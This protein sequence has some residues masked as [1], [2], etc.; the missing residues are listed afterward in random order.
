MGLGRWFNVICRPLQPNEVPG[1]VVPRPLQQASVQQ[2]RP[3]RASDV[4][5]KAA[6]SPPSRR[7]ARQSKALHT[8]VKDIVDFV[9]VEVLCA[10][11]CVRA[12]VYSYDPEP[13]SHTSPATTPLQCSPQR[14]LACCTK[15]GTIANGHFVC[16]RMCACMVRVH[17][18]V[19]ACMHVGVFVPVPGTRSSIF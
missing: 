16:V 3:R 17:V 14:P 2:P 8:K 11:V 13:V 12:R 7:V 1:Q 5:A 6:L 10:H 9:L 19:H 4:A 18:G 15:A